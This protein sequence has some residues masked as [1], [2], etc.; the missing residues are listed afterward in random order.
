MHS[1]WHEA[2]AECR[3]TGGKHRRDRDECQQL[4]AG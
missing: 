4:A 1:I 3:W 2:N